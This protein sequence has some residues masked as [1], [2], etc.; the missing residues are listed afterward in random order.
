MTD[1]RGIPPPNGMESYDIKRDNDLGALN[2]EQQ[3]KLN[4]HKVGHFKHA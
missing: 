2:D 3:E 1:R 4:Q